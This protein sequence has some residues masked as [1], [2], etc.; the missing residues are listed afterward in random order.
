M[1]VNPKYRNETADLWFRSEDEKDKER[2]RRF[3]KNIGS[4]MYMLIGISFIVMGLYVLYG[5]R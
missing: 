2:K 1:M 3:V 4:L 5:P